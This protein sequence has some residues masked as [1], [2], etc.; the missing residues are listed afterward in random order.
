MTHCSII[1]A[2][3]PQQVKDAG[4]VDKAVAHQMEPFDENGHWFRNGSRWDWWVIGG[5]NSGRFLGKDVIVRSE[6]TEAALKQEQEKRARDTWAKYQAEE[7]K[8]NF[9]R[10]YLYNLKDDDTEESLV[11]RYR[12]R[13]LSAFAFLRDRTWYEAHRAGWFGAQAA[14]EC[15]IEADKRGEEYAGRCIHRSHK[16]SAKIV[17]FDEDS[18]RWGERYWRRFILAL[19]P[20]TTLV[21]VDYHV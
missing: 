7:R 9:V 3:S 20:E 16:L 13:I 6:L 1:V 8:D 5:R 21:G 17:S 18:D 4:D 12:S 19:P 10:G 11:E 15:E 14:T 2:L